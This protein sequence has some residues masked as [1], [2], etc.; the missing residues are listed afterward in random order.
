[1][2]LEWG[3]PTTNLRGRMVLEMA[4]RCKLVVQNGGNRL[5]YE[6][7]GLGASIPDITLATEGA[8]GKIT[9][10]AITITSP[11]ECWRVPHNDLRTERVRWVGMSQRWTRT[12]SR[13][14]FES[15]Q[16]PSPLGMEEL[17]ALARL[18][19]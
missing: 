1:M 17:Q 13:S 8:S 4:T 19:S 18:K 9:M 11:S 16:R 2:A 6:R 7:A 10:A 12:D 3:M 5:T 15:S 14:I